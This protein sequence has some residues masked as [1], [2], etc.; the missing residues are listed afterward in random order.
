M[1]F[2]VIRIGSQRGAPAKELIEVSQGQLRSSVREKVL[3]VASCRPQTI[4]TLTTQ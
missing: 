2:P 1:Y 4:A 3:C